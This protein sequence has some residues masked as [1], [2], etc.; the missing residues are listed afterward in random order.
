MWHLPFCS[1]STHPLIAHASF[2]TLP[3]SSVTV[4]SFHVGGAFLLRN[5][6][7]FLRSAAGITLFL[8]L[9]AQE[10]DHPH[11]EKR[12]CGLDKKKVH[13][14]RLS[15]DLVYKLDVLFFALT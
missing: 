7:G 1:K 14:L 11:H 5:C 10:A 12:R 6:A 3:F 9:A 13:H 8:M 15:P 2:L 4:G